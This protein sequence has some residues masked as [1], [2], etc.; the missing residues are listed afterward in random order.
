MQRR[1]KIFNAGFDKFDLEDQINSWAQENF[2]KILNV[3]ISS[4]CYRH[5]DGDDELYAVVVYE[6]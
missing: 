6:D 1:I 4:V 5:S 2:A 3:S